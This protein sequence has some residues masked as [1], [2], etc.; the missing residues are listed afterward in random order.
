VG[1]GDGAEGGG[2]LG[3]GGEHGARSS[4]R[5]CS[6]PGAAARQSAPPTEAHGGCHAPRLARTALLRQTAPALGEVPVGNPHAAR[7][8]VIRLRV[9]SW[10]NPGFVVFIGI[11]PNSETFPLEISLYLYKV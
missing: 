3:A 2:D 6:R 8:S 5:P 4:F 11:A 7:P 9:R 1:G 10:R